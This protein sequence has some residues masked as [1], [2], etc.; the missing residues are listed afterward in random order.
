MINNSRAIIQVSM[1]AYAKHEIEM[2]RGVL[3]SVSSPFWMCTFGQASKDSL[4]S[5][6]LQPNRDDSKI[7]KKLYGI[8]RPFKH[9]K[10]TR[11]IDSKGEES[12]N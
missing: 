7:P 8:S 5:I 12:S 3:N 1:S 4:A 9:C 10:C 6:N 11:K 2:C